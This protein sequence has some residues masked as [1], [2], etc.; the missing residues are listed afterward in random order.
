MSKVRSVTPR[1]S[2]RSQIASVS[3]WAV[4]LRP[5]GVGE[6]IESRAVNALNEDPP[7]HHEF[8]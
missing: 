4:T 6:F 7:R 2:R 1:Y 3:D 8:Q 5:G